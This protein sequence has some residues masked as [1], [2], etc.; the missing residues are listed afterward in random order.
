MSEVI[1]SK[2]SDLTDTLITPSAACPLEDINRIV[3]IE[4]HGKFACK[5]FDINTKECIYSFGSYQTGEFRYPV[6]VCLIG[7]VVCVSDHWRMKIIL[8]TDEGDF[9]TDI[10]LLATPWTLCY[11]TRRSNLYVTSLFKNRVVRLSPE[12]PYQLYIGKKTLFQPLCV[13]VNEQEMIFVL[14]K[15]TRITYFQED[16]EVLGNISFE[17]L[18]PWCSESL[19]TFVMDEKGNFI[20]CPSKINSIVVFTGKG[21]QIFP[22]S[23]KQRKELNLDNPLHVY[24]DIRWAILLVC[25]TYH[26]RIQIFDYCCN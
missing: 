8:F 19:A 24:L 2:L 25:D 12:L 16:G 1:I 20:L 13:C 18:D 17:K 11:S 21:K 14:D 9:I 3:V 15:T 23:N 22:K 5:V 4:R 6:S 7:S 10:H 26:G